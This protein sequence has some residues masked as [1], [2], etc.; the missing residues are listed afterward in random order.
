V[1][2]RPFELA[3]DSVTIYQMEIP[4]NTQIYQEMKGARTAR[5][6]GFGF[7]GGGLGEKTPKKT[8]GGVFSPGFKWPASGGPRGF[9]EKKGRGG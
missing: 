1:C 6:A 7:W 9:G 4:T 3:P 8:R 5:G 2:V